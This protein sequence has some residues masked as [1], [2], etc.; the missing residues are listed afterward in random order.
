MNA[1]QGY[2]EELAK[3][4]E[5]LRVLYARYRSLGHMAMQ[6][7]P[8][9]VGCDK[10]LYYLKNQYDIRFKERDTIK[11]LIL[12]QKNIQQ[13]AMLLLELEHAIDREVKKNENEQTRAGAA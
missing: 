1:I 6:K 11:K 13:Q 4:R 5:S 10:G 8:Y 12:L 2:R 7:M 9:A 3:R